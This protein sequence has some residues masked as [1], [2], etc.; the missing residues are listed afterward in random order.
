MAVSRVRHADMWLCAA[1]RSAQAKQRPQAAEEE[2]PEERGE[3]SSRPRQEPDATARWKNN[4]KRSRIA[5]WSE[6]M[7]QM[8]ETSFN[9]EGRRLEHQKELSKRW[10]MTTRSK[11]VA[12]ENSRRPMVVTS[13]V[14]YWLEFGECR[15]ENDTSVCVVVRTYSL[16]C[17]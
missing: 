9:A 5:V 8:V 13:L 2:R 4:E 7:Q 6:T 10:R 17:P 16:C 14:V 11:A 15:V 3:R 12:G 1:Q